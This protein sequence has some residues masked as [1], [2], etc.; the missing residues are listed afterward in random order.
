MCKSWSW[1]CCDIEKDSYS[2]QELNSSPLAHNY[3]FYLVTEAFGSRIK[4][5]IY[6]TE[7]YS[8]SCRFLV[9][10][11]LWWFFFSSSFIILVF[12]V[13]C[14]CP[15]VSIDST[16]PYYFLQEQPNTQQDATQTVVVYCCTT[17]AVALEG[18][19]SSSVMLCG[20]QIVPWNFIPISHQATSWTAGVPQCEGSTRRLGS[21]CSLCDCGERTA[22]S[23]TC[24]WETLN[25]YHSGCR[26]AS[27][28]HSLVCPL[29]Q[30]VFHS[31]FGDLDECLHHLAPCH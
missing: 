4:M 3:L 19:Y 8:H 23:C 31:Y 29:I 9:L 14:V 24:V 2:C 18:N 16:D 27:Q 5:F 26:W 21:I 30:N 1:C 20:L 11:S 12:R 10:H 25:F 28:Q 7:S 15:V 13:T 17:F 22:K 6:P